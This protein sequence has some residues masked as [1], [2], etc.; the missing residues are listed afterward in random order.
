MYAK[1]MPFLAASRAVGRLLKDADLAR[2][3]A[4]KKVK[5][6]DSASQSFKGCDSASQRLKGC[7]L[8]T[9]CGKRTARATVRGGS[10]IRGAWSV[11]GVRGYSWC[12]STED[13]TT[14][15]IAVAHIALRSSQQR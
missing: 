4:Q 11:E 14:E 2:W 12:Q 7:E 5:G 8:D 6:C 9:G 1:F 3:D 13:D 10:S 15:V